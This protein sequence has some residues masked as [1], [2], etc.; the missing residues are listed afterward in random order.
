MLTRSPFMPSSDS[1]VTWTLSNRCHPVITEHVA[2]QSIVFIFL[3]ASFS[4]TVSIGL[5]WVG[6]RGVKHIC[7]NCQTEQKTVQHWLKVCTHLKQSPVSIL[8]ENS[9][10]LLGPERKNIYFIFYEKMKY[11]SIQILR[12]TCLED[13]LW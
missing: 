13:N 11:S 4:V 10:V 8:Y 2:L 5:V 1:I 9:E 6:E 12:I 7:G 3:Q